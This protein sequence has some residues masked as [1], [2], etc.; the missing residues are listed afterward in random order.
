MAKTS[1]PRTS[2]AKADG[3]ED[4]ARQC[5]EAQRRLRRGSRMLH[6]EI[7]SLLAAAGL[8]LQLLRMDFPDANARA[9]EIAEALD[10]AMEHVRA[11]SRELEPSPVRRTGL[12]HA[13][14][15]LAERQN[16]G[17]RISVRYSSAAVLHP[18]TA[19]AVYRAAERCV[20]IAA[21]ARGATRVS[22]AVSGSRTLCVRIRDDGEA[23]GRARSLAHAA[24]LARCAGLQFDIQTKEST[25]VVIRYAM[26]GSSGR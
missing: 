14:L 4:L 23:R 22:I 11:L 8:R 10:A 6:D 18:E 13:L 2:A 20:E 24:L 12:K 25:I 15:Q 19:D 21:A 5:V 3:A 16:G 17:P 9:A 7:G 26:H 1:L